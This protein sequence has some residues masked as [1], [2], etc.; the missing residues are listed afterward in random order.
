MAKARTL[1]ATA[2][3]VM[4]AIPIGLPPSEGYEAKQAQHG[5]VTLAQPT[6]HLQAQL[7]PEAATAFLRMRNGLR[8]QNAKLAGGKPVWTNVDALR[9]LMEQVSA[10][11]A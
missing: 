4:I 11:V 9:W 10:E 8:G 3:E 7:G 2:E 1:E 5:K 6:L